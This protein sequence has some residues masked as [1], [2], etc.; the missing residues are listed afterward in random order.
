MPEV[1]CKLVQNAFPPHADLHAVSNFLSDQPTTVHY[2]RKLAWRQA[3]L[4]IYIIPFSANDIGRRRHE[5]SKQLQVLHIDVALFQ[6]HIWNPT[7]GFL[8]QITTSIKSTDTQQENVELLLQ[9][10]KAPPTAM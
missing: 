1:P 4:I 7:R 9:L 3:S 10:E 5:L 2:I 6:R 8:F